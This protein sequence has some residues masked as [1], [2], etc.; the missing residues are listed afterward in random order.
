MSRLQRNLEDLP[1]F[2][3]AIQKKSK[4]MIEYW[5]KRHLLFSEIANFGRYMRSRKESLQTFEA[6]VD[7]S[8]TVFLVCFPA[9]SGH[10]QLIK[11]ADFQALPQMD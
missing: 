4:C 8:T 11:N 6:R 2:F 7:S 9:G 3:L 1:F 10:R 5:G